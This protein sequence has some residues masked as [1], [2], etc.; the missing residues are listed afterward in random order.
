MKTSS[1][2]ATL[3]FGCQKLPIFRFWKLVFCTTYKEWPYY[4][5]ENS[6]SQ[7]NRLVAVT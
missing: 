1:E 4:E 7:L 6:R 3:F 5:S 2:L